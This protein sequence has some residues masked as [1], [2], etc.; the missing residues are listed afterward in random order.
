MAIA[1]IEVLEKKIEELKKELAELKRSQPP[2]PVRDYAFAGQEGDVAL[3]SLFGDKD[4]LLVIH[5]MGRGCVYCTL[6][7]DGFNG[8]L[9]HLEDRASVVL[10]SPDPPEV[11]R[12]FAMSRG[13]RFR[14]VSDRDREFSKDMDMLVE[15]GVWPGVSGFRRQPDGSI[16]RI[17]K[18]YFGPGDDFCSVWPLF[19]HLMNGA[20]DWEP[21]YRY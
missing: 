9:P 1:E 8:V 21:K 14:M 7:A 20:N 12:E 19:D 17:A 13:W 11:Q 10:V 5:N 4:D 18:S 2:Q 3:S 15:G 6:W 16:V